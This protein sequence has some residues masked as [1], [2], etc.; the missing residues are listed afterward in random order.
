LPQI[1][2]FFNSSNHGLGS[3]LCW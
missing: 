2:Y 1:I 3:I